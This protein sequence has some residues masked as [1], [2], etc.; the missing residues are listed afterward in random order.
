MGNLLILHV[1][2]RS[3]NAVDGTDP[4]SSDALCTDR[5]GPESDGDKDEAESR[6]NA[7]GD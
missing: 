1:F 3:A 5:D 4:N 2:Q 6:Q 7:Q